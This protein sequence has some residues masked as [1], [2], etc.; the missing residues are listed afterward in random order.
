MAKVEKSALVPFSAQAMFELV[1]DVS[2]YPQFLPWCQSARLL[3]RN[4]RELC[5]EIQ[6]ARAGIK[7]SFSTF[8][9]LYP[10]ERIDLRL[11]EGPFKRLDGTWRFDQLRSNACKVSLRMEFE[12]SGRLINVAFGKVFSQIADSLVD[13]FCKRAR[14]LYGD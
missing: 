1:N 5:G 9:Q 2:S 7:Q 4:A 6:I 14:D 12:F 11:R 10:Y 8:N 13:A 3:S